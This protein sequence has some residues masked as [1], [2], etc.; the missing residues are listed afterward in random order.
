MSSGLISGMRIGGIAAY[1]PRYRVSNS[2]IAARLRKERH[3]SQRGKPQ[4]RRGKLDRRQEKL[5]KT[6]DRWIQRF[7]G[8]KERRFAADNE[9]TI[10]LAAR[11]ALLLLDR[12]DLKASEIDGIVFGTVTPSY[13]NS[14]PDAAL[15][16]DRLGIPSVRW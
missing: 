2:R 16:Q 3:E 14:P 13:L 4:Q 11:A 9:G 12:T 10:D 7:I 5:Y 15:L 1:A 6:S 8:F